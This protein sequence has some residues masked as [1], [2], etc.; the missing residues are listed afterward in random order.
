VIDARQIDQDEM[1]TRWRHKRIGAAYRA[2]HPSS[3]PAFELPTLGCDAEMVCRQLK[4][5][6]VSLEKR[7]RFLMIDQPAH[8]GDLQERHSL[9]RGKSGT[10]R[11]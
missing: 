1:F 2:A 10:G 7:A 8:D 4:S 11:R 6:D 5:R 3:Q 9:H